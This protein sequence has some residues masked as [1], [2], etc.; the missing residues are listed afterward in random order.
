MRILVF[1][2]FLCFNFFTSHAQSNSNSVNAMLLVNGKECDHCTLELTKEHLK[3]IILSTNNE[4]V[5]ILEFKLKTPGLATIPAKGHKLSPKIAAA[6][7]KVNI[8]S[9]IQFFGI[10]TNKG[11]LRNT[12]IVK[13]I[14]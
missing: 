6:L 11:P 8:G 14:N 2:L 5:K 12:L 7:R 3:K 13:L 4:S 1:S 9:S 10:K